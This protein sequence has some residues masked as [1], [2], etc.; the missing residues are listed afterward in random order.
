[1]G[2]SKKQYIGAIEDEKEAAQT[3]D[4]HAIMMQ[5]IRVSKKERHHLTIYDEFL[6]YYS[7]ESFLIFDIYSGQDKLLLHKRPAHEHG[8]W[9]Q[10]NSGMSSSGKDS[11]R[12]ST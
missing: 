10:T 5:G 6:Y 7:V 2:K 12:K 4:W 11:R 9:L 8:H 3:Y 1:M